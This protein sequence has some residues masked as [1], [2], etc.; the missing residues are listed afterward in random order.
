MA[1]LNDAH[2]G[3]ETRFWSPDKTAWLDVKPTMGQVL[4]FQQRLLVHSGEEVTS[5]TKYTL[6]TDCMFERV[7]IT[8]EER[9]R[10][11]EE[12]EAAARRDG[13]DLFMY[14]VVGAA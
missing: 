2:E 14:D 11:A 5:G 6:R 10:A 8:R 1:Y 13:Q 7:V 4:I 12:A 9:K 3:G